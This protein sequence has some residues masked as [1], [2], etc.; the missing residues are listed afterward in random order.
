MLD[1]TSASYQNAINVTT[2]TINGKNYINGITLPIEAISSV[3]L[4]FYKVDTSKDYTYPNL[5][6]DSVVSVIPQ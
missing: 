1:N 2:E 3:D 5:E 6:N 4:R